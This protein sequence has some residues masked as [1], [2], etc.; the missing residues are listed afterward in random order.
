MTTIGFTESARGI[1]NKNL[2]LGVA[3]GHLYSLDMRQVHPRRPLSEPSQP[4]KEEVN[5][6][7]FHF[8]IEFT[9]NHSIIAHNIYVGS[10]AIQSIC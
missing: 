3:P 6:L 4:E 1:A 7:I 2:L 10:Y 5:L 8:Y 9:Y